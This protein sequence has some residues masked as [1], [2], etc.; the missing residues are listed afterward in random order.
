MDKNCITVNQKAA[1]Q[2][3]ANKQF[4]VTLG[5]L[6]ERILRFLWHL[7]AFIGIQRSVQHV[8]DVSKRSENV[9]KLEEAESSQA[10]L[11]R[12]DRY[13]VLQQ[14]HTATVSPKGENMLVF[15][16]TV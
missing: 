1:L 7:L 13:V 15:T 10:E 2:Q 6:H 3:Q 11:T 8:Q 12:V 14:T 9:L 4:T 5:T 16:C